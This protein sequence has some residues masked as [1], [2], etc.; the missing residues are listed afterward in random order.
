MLPYIQFKSPLFYFEAISQ[1]GYSSHFHSYVPTGHSR[2][3]STW[4][5][6]PFDFEGQYLLRSSSE[7]NFNASKKTAWPHKI[8]HSS[9]SLQHA[10]CDRNCPSTGSLWLHRG[11]C[12]TGIMLI[13]NGAVD[14][15]PAKI[16]FVYAKWNIISLFSRDNLFPP[17]FF[18]PSMHWYHYFL[19]PGERARSSTERIT[20]VWIH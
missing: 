18:H 16:F 12:S 15:K 11:C 20:I 9:S 2:G 7:H 17:L 1:L 13:V 6:L 3:K 19:P 5:L 8:H 4:V 14:G 10:V